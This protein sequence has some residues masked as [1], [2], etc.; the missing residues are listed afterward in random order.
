[1]IE[2]NESDEWILEI[3]TES[4]NDVDSAVKTAIEEVKKWEV[5]LLID[6]GEIEVSVDVSDDTKSIIED[7]KSQVVG[8]YTD[9]NAEEII[10]DHLDP[11]IEEE[12]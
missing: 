10:N 11:L 9:D 8:N 1:M 6:N 4:W 5:M 3:K 7:I 12:V 2:L